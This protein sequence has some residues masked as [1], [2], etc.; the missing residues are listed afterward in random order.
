[1]Q[2][3][4]KSEIFL[5]FCSKREYQLQNRTWQQKK[6]F[7]HDNLVE[8]HK[9]NKGQPIETELNSEVYLEEALK[10]QR[11]KFLLR[12]IKLTQGL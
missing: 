5:E 1:M 8:L 6:P 3:I 12:D 11:V 2:C 10:F 7:G 9:L 4:K